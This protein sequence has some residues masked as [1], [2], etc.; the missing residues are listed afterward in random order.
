MKDPARTSVPGAECLTIL[1]ISPFEE[2]HSRLEA[3]IGRESRLVTAQSF[4]AAKRFLESQNVF[5]VICE[6]DSPPTTW[7]ECLDYIQSLPAP[8]FLIVTSR[9]AD[10]RLWAEVLNLG[11]WDVLAKPFDD[12]EVSRT[13]RSTMERY[14][15][16]GEVIAKQLN[17]TAAS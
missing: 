16:S 12:R 11:G 1:S 8:P 14:R 13:V 7:I 10:E 9:L 17:L 6:R 15:Y 4:S 3:I 2:D 5:L